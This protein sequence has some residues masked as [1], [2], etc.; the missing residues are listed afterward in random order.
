MYFFLNR[1][2]PLSRS[3]APR[4]VYKINRMLLKGFPTNLAKATTS[5]PF[6]VWFADAKTLYVTDEGNATTSFD[7]TNGISDKESR[8]SQGSRDSS[9]AIYRGMQFYHWFLD[10]PSHLVA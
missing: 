2:K 10:R 9:D 6:G 8:G 3:A 4:I 5:F 1:E 7:P